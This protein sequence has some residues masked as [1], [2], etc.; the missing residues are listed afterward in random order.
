MLGNEGGIE[1]DP[2]SRLFR[3]PEADFVPAQNDV[4]LLQVPRSSFQISDMFPAKSPE[5]SLALRNE[6]VY[7]DITCRR[8]L[9]ARNV[10]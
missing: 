1:K 3:V 6:G 2:D 9:S 7:P 4:D 8:G 10:V 5:E